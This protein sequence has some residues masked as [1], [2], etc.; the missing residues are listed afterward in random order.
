MELSIDLLKVNNAIIN[1]LRVQVHARVRLLRRDLS[2]SEPHVS[3]ARAQRLGVLLVIVELDL[4]AADPQDA[5]NGARSLPSG[6]LE[7]AKVDDAV[8]LVVAHDLIDVGGEGPLDLVGAQLAHDGGDENV[9]RKGAELVSHLVGLEVEPHGDAE[10]QLGDKDKRGP[11][12]ADKAGLGEGV[13]PVG[14]DRLPGA[15]AELGDAV[16]EGNAGA[17]VELIGV[18]GENL[19]LIDFENVGEELENVGDAGMNTTTSVTPTLLSGKQRIND[20]LP[21]TVNSV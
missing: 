6:L 18:G 20:L 2:D 19:A 9:E 11:K 17:G 12:A 15:E 13:V 21:L 1:A 3:L 8:L 14:V 7:D 5:V 16:G 4:R 10:L